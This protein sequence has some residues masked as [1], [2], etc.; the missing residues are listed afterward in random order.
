MGTPSVDEKRIMLLAP[1][2]TP[3]AF[4]VLTCLSLTPLHQL[5][6]V[7][8]SSVVVIWLEYLDSILLLLLLPKIHICELYTSTHIFHHEPHSFFPWFWKPVLLVPMSRGRENIS[9]I[10][11]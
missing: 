11:R 1:V 9:P 4:H 8:A 10:G 5:A 3:A 6:N 2:I 7:T